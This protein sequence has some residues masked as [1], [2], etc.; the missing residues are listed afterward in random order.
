MTQTLY[1]LGYTG[2][3]PEQL[4]RLV[5]DLGEVVVDT[6]YSP[7]SRAVQWTRLRLTGLLG[8]S[9]QHLPSLGNINYKGDGPIVINKPEEGVPQVAQLLEKQPVILLCVCAE[10]SGC[11]RKVV[12]ELMQEYS[13]CEVVHLSAKDITS[14]TPAGQLF[15]QQDYSVKPLPQPTDPGGTLTLNTQPLPLHQKKMF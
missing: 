10:V 4:Q 5:Q 6:R 15:S 11:H 7:R 9:Y 2:I 13:G 8:R 1:T 12:A 14:P 3:K